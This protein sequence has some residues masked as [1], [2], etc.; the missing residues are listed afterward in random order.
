MRNFLLKSSS[1]IVLSE[2]AG[3]DKKEKAQTVKINSSLALYQNPWEQIAYYENKQ[4]TITPATVRQS[5]TADCKTKRRKPMTF[6]QPQGTHTDAHTSHKNTSLQEK[7]KK[8]RKQSD[9]KNNPEIW[10]QLLAALPNDIVARSWRYGGHEMLSR[11]QTEDAHTRLHTQTHRHTHKQPNWS[12]AVGWSDWG[13]WRKARLHPSSH[14]SQ[15]RLL[16]F[17]R[18]GSASELV[19]GDAT[20]TLDIRQF[21]CVMMNGKPNHIEKLTH[22]SQI[23]LFHFPPE[24]IGPWDATLTLDVRQFW[25]LMENGKLNH[26]KKKVW[27][28]VTF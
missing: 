19:N 12:N 5:I 23:C 2:A 25:S 14:S 27:P 1:E 4:V 18:N 7:R 10:N 15:N 13:G 22:S 17:R 20:L 8:E 9:E 28:L 6:K 26:V 11:K 3:Q 24:W 21:R 16:I